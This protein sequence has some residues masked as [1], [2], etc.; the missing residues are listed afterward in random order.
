MSF[1][2]ALRKS[3]KSVFLRSEEALDSPFGGED[4]PLRH[5]GAVGMYLLWLVVASGLYLYTVLDTGID[6]VYSSIGDLSL[7]QWYLG[8]VLRLSLIHI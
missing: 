4:N 3:A 1:H 6:A 5:L 2:S 7:A 8:G